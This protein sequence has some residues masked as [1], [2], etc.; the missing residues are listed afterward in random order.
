MQVKQMSIKGTI[1]GME[2]LNSFNLTNKVMLKLL[3]TYL[4]K[5]Q[6]KINQLAKWH[7]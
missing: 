6:K 1:L 7:I 3:I 5:I 4:S 2:K